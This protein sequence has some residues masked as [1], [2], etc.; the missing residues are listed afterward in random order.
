MR[1]LA[2]I[3]NK[4]QV[5]GSEVQFIYQPYSGHPAQVATFVVVIAHR[6]PQLPKAIPNPS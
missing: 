6:F 4:E 2:L 5:Q 1:N 3:R